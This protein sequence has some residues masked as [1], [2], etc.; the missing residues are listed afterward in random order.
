M[1]VITLIDPED[2]GNSAL[3]WAT[4]HCPSFVTCE[5]TDVSDLSYQYDI[6]VNY[7]FMDKNDAIYFALAWKSQ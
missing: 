2:Q 4:E 1:E 5:L 7:Q 3:I 6:V